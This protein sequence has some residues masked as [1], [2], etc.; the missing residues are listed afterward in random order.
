VWIAKVDP[1]WCRLAHGDDPEKYSEDALEFLERLIQ[2][3]PYWSA[4][5]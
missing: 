4:F 5:W 2:D 3:E 1:R